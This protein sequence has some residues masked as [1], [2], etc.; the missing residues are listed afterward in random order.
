[1]VVDTSAL[2]AI[3]LGEPE[4][5]ALVRALAAA[6]H[7]VIGAPTL[8]EASAVMR[9]R[10]GPGGEIALDA[11]LE[12]LG[13]KV[14]AFSVD[15]ARMARLGYGRFGKGVGDPAVLNLGDCFSYGTTMALRQPLLCKGD[16]FARTDVELV[17]HPAAG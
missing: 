9:A 16:D 6:E 1:M 8:V 2:L 3:L 13:I 15:Q 7:A 14:E 17:S 12:R 10:K 11:L 4:A 5:E